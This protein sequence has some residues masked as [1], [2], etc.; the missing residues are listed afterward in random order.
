MIKNTVKQLNC[1]ISKISVFPFDN[2]W[3]CNLYPWFKA[4]FISLQCYMIFQNWWLLLTKHL[5][6]LSMLKVFTA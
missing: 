6:L 3:K 5:L 2:I 4:V 1:E